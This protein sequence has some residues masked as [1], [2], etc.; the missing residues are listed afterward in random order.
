VRLIASTNICCSNCGKNVIHNSN[1]R[2]ENILFNFLELKKI[3]IINIP[4]NILEKIEVKPVK[5]ID[6]VLQ[7]ALQRMPEPAEKIEEVAKNEKGKSARN[8]NKPLRH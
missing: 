2:T 3:Q 7:V 8:S 1:N 4:K 6:E 5:W